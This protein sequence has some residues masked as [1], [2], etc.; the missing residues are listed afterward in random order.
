MHEMS[1]IIIVKLN[2]TYNFLLIIFKVHFKLHGLL[3]VL[4]LLLSENH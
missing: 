2:K 1:L 4:L 3:L